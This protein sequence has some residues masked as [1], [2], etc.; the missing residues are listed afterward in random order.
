VRKNL[1]EGG[2]DGLIYNANN[3]EEALMVA[4]GWLRMQNI[5]LI[6]SRC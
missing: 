3:E 5:R 1:D 2:K 6:L 4:H